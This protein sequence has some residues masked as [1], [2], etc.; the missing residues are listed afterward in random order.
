MTDETD[1]TVDEIAAAWDAAEPAE[2]AGRVRLG[3]RLK[4]GLH[5]LR[6]TECRVTWSSWLRRLAGIRSGYSP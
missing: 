3:L 6:C 4:A 1:R 5:E 2:V